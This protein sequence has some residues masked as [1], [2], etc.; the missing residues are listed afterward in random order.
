MATVTSARAATT[1]I[2]T[3]NTDAATGGTGISKLVAFYV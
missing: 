3:V 1:L 2:G